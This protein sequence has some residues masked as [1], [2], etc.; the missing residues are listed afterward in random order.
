MSRHGPEGG[1]Q[2]PNM[3]AV[4]WHLFTGGAESPV[5]RVS[6]APARLPMR[7]LSPCVSVLV[8]VLAWPAVAGAQTIETVGER[9]MGMGG[10]FVAVA[11]DSTA[12]WWNPAALAAGPFLDAAAGWSRTE[13]RQEGEPAGRVEPV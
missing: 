13:F 5:L 8:C 10:A 1:A 11:D 6:D 3:T 9:A 12:T 2:P 4:H 7:R